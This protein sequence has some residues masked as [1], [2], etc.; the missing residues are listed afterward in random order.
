MKE[1]KGNNNINSREDWNINYNHLKVKCLIGSYAG[2]LLKYE[3][4]KC[5]ALKINNL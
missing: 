4:L 2:Y 3:K 1:N 5:L